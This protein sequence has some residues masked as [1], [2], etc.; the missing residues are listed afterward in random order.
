MTEQKKQLAAQRLLAPVIREIDARI[1]GQG[2]ALCVMDGQC[3]AGKTTLA[4]ALAARYGAPVIHMDDFFLP[5]EMRTPERLAQPGGNVHYERF[6]AQVLEALQ[7]GACFSYQ[8]FDC[9]T[10]EMLD[11]YCPWAALR[12]VE[13][14]YSLHPRFQKAWVDMNA[15]TV[16]LTVDERE[17]L[18]RIALRAPEKLPQFESRWIPLEKSYFQAYDIPGRAEMVLTSLPWEDKT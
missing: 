2:H 4:E 14:S 18:R 7:S 1:A 17:Q 15:V 9:A 6:E 10:G 11:R 8:R 12:V 16:F 3:G 5:Y 13:G